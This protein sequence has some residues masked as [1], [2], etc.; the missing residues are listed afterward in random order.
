MIINGTEVKLVAHSEV[1]N[2]VRLLQM[3]DHELRR[4]GWQYWTSHHCNGTPHFS[5]VIYREDTGL[6]LA[7]RGAAQAFCTANVELIVQWR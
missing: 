4:N 7:F 1:E 3:G 2:S 5:G 6:G